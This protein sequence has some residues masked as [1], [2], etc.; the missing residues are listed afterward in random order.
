M[1]AILP[2]KAALENIEAMAVKLKPHGYQ[3][4]VIDNGRLGK[5][6]LRKGTSFPA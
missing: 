3:Y 1:P 2:E 5:C 6:K 4:F